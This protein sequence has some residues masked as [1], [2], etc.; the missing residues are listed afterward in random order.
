[1]P[2]NHGIRILENPTSIP[3]PVSTDGFVPVFVGTSAVNLAADISKAVNKPILCHTFAEFADAFGYSDD[4]ASYTLSACADAMFKA[5]G[6][7]PAVFINVLDPANANHT[8][9]YTESITLSNKVGVGTSKGVLLDSSLVVKNGN[10]TLDIDDDYT[11]E[12]DADGYPVF[13]VIAAGVT[14]IS[15]TGK[16]L[17]ATGVTAAEVI[18]SY[19]SATGVY[20]GIQCADEVYTKLQVVPSLL[21]APGFSKTASV[22][23]ALSEKA[24]RLSS[25]FRCECVVDIDATSSG[26]QVYSDVATKKTA[27]GFLNENMICVWPMA[28]Y[29]EKIMPYSALYVAMCIYTDINNEN[30]PNLSPSNKPIKASAMCDADGNEIYLDDDRANELNAVGVVTAVNHNGFRSWGNNTAAYPGTTDPK[31][32]WIGCRRFFSWWGNRFIVTYADKIDDPA[33][34]RLIESFVDSENVFAN[35]LVASDKCAGLRMEYRQEDNQIGE[36]LNG[37]ITF[38]EYL[39]PYTPAEYV[40]DILEYDP[41]MVEEALGGGEA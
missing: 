1:M 26:A 4:Y 18:G 14:A 6:V 17:A 2:Y 29:A 19:T 33:N 13:T 41:S 37:K 25:K 22:G 9:T 38:R 24:S 31:D 3:A 7:G 36:V 39:A 15:V 23:L 8:T 20:T 16:K 12:F 34:Y 40:L 27:A 5:F 21:A 10:T 11:V 35:G 28:K 32:R 30:V